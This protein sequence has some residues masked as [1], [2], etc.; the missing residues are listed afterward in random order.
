[1]SHLNVE[2]KAKCPNHSAI[3]EVLQSRNARGPWIIHQTDTYFNCPNGKLK[4]REAPDYAELI[5]YIRE[6]KDGP[7]QSHITF[8]KPSDASE[9]KNILSKAYGILVIVEKQRE[10]YNIENI[11]FHLDIVEGLGNFLEIEAI[12]YEGKFG[13]ENLFFQCQEY[14]GLFQIIKN[15]LI[16][17]SYSDLLLNI[18]N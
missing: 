16:V 4:L 10:I 11:Q 3:R 5:H 8:Y 15:D 7:K 18:K 13:E 1:M 9:L 6:Q 14:L 12:D 2:I 17:G